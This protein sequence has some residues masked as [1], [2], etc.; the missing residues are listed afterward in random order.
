ME[1]EKNFNLSVGLRIREIREAMHM[2]RERF[3]ELCDI[4]DSFLTAV[5]NGKKSITSKTIFK[6]CTNAQISADYLILGSQPD[7]ET[8]T[9]LELFKSMTALERDYAFRIL[10][11]YYNAMNSVKARSRQESLRSEL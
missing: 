8:D 1:I 10:K 3:S 11:E 9:I 6:I 4:S 2:T 7:F 5:E